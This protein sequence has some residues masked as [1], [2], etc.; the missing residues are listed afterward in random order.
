MNN[1]FNKIERLKRKARR[2]NIKATTIPDNMDC[3]IHMAE[4]IRP[5]IAIARINF[6]NIM[7]ELSTL[8]PTAPNTR[9]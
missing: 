9:L 8:D 5:D 4:I 6:N 3:G 2:Q 1:P 7:D